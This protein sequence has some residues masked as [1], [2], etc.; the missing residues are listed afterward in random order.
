MKETRL[1]LE[2]VKEDILSID[3]NRYKLLFGNI[4]SIIEDVVDSIDEI[5]YKQD[6]IEENIKYIDEDIAGLQDELFEEVSIE[7][8]NQLEDEYVEINCKNCGKPLFVEKETIDSKKNIPC[9]F[10]NNEAM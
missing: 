3:D 9:P 1:K 6:S 10:C 8:L 5:E 7:D 4:L 2:K